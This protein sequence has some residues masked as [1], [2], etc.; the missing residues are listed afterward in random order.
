MPGTPS[1]QYSLTLRVEIE[2][3]PQMLGKVAIAIGAADGTIGA[4]DLVQVSSG[5]GTG[6]T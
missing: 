6:Y 3:R 2:H 1:A 5:P 4:V